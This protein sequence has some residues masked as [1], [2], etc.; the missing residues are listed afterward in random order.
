MKILKD[1]KLFFQNAF[2]PH[3]KE[4]GLLLRED[5][6]IMPI[7]YSKELLTRVTILLMKIKEL[8]DSTVTIRDIFAN[9]LP[10]SIIVEE[11][12]KEI[13]D[14]DRYII[15]MGIIGVIVYSSYYGPK[16][17]YRVVD[18]TLSKVY[19]KKISL[20]QLDNIVVPVV[21]TII[22]EGEKILDNMQ[23]EHDRKLKEYDRKID[24]EIN[25]ILEDLET[26]KSR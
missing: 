10:Q 24:S 3:L 1:S 17:N 19:N 22:D 2:I 13:D 20:Q 18:N 8:K 11:Y 21:E 5:K 16:Y 23:K 12:P 4:G 26:W 15:R 14:L 9:H 25:K 7:R 6:S